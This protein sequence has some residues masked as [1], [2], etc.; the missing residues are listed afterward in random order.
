MQPESLPHPSRSVIHP[1][2]KG[3][4]PIGYLGQASPPP[5]PSAHLGR[6]GVHVRTELL[7]SVRSTAWCPGPADRQK[8]LASLAGAQVLARYLARGERALWSTL[9]VC[10]V[11]G[12]KNTWSLL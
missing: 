10:G 9:A 4:L 3:K 8:S 2:P 6:V 1:F 5:P 12:M 11:A 7:S